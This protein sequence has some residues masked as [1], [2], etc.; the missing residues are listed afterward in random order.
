M[1]KAQKQMA[2]P[3]HAAAFQIAAVRGFMVRPP[4]NRPATNPPASPPMW[5][6]LSAPITNPK[7]IT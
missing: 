3:A 2:T 7:R 4:I 5:A 6:K 1:K